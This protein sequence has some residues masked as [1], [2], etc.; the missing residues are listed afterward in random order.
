MID[1]NPAQNEPEDMDV[2]AWLPDEK[3]E[4]SLPK[5]GEMRQGRIARIS[6]TEILIEIGTK[7][8]GVLS[9]QELAS[10]PQAQRDALLVPLLTNKRIAWSE[11]CFIVTAHAVGSSDN[12]CLAIHLLRDEVHKSITKSTPHQTILFPQAIRLSTGRIGN[13]IPNPRRHDTR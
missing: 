3:P 1:I 13:S 9:E 12:S 5:P 10:L 7:S 2:T 11:G 4:D 6:P 8:E